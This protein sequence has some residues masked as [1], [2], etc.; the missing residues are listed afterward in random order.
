MLVIGTIGAMI[1]GMLIPSISLIMG[2]VADTF[3]NGSDVSQIHSTIEKTAKWIAI[4]AA[5]I[6]FFGY[7]FFAFW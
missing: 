1:A 4:V 7:V 2:S 5:S 6:F 3:G